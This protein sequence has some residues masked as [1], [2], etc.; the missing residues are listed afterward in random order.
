[1][2]TVSVIMPA[3]NVAPYIGAAIDSVLAQTVPGLGTAHRRRRLDRR[4]GGPRR[5]R[6]TPTRGSGC[7]N[8]DNGGISAARNTALGTPPAT[9]SPSSTATTCGSPTSS[10]RSSRFSPPS[11]TS[12]SSPATAGFLAAGSTAAP[13]GR[14]RT[15]GRS[16]RCQTILADEMAIF[17]M[18]IFRRRVYDAIGGFDET[19]RSNEDYDFWLRAAVAGFT[20]RRNDKPLGH[21]RRRDDS[22]SAQDVRMLAGILRVYGNIRPLLTDRPAELRILERQRVRFERERLAAQARFALTPASGSR[23]RPS[24]SAVRARR[25]RGRQSRQLHGPA[26]TAAAVPRLSVAPRRQRSVVTQVP[27]GGRARPTAGLRRSIAVGRLG[28]GAR[29]SSRHERR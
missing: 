27:A 1:M 18:S 3:Y 21:Y 9:S 8:R 10:P 14:R 7:C 23:R 16:R 4:H 17:I 2:A 19:L 5:P 29:C 20:F 26:H 24:R 11:R 6:P 15:S 12:T 25:R 13:P 22:V 28:G